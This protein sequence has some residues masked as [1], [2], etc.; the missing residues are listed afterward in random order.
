MYNCP[1]R[2]MSFRDRLVLLCPFL[3]VCVWCDERRKAYCFLE[4]SERRRVEDRCLQRCSIGHGASQ[5][6]S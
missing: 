4:R 3:D 2:A 1:G 6:F 5:F